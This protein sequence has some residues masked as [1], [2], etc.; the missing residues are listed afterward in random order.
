MMAKYYVRQFSSNL[1]DNSNGCKNIFILCELMNSNGNFKIHQYRIAPD[2][3]YGNI[4]ILREII[5]AGF[6]FAK[7][8]SSKIEIREDKDRFY[9]WLYLP[10]NGVI[11]Q[12]QVTGERV[13]C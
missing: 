3:R 11:E 7:N 10:I 2:V 5:E 1:L 6:N 12:L 13:R 4:N 8:T 9:L